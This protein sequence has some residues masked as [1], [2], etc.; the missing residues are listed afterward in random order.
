MR[1]TLLG[2]G[3]GT[4]ESVTAEACAAMNEADLVTGAPRL[5]EA[6]PEIPGQ[7]RV[8]SVRAGEILELL[9]GAERV[10]V[11][12]SGDTGFYSGARLLIPELRA[13]GVEYRV[14]P[15]ISS[16][17]ILA[18]RLGRPWQDWN[19]Y[20][21]HGVDCDPVAAVM[22]DKPAFFLTGGE[23]GPAELCHMLTDVSL[24]DLPVTVGENLTRPDERIL[25]G[26][27]AEF[28]ERHFAPLSVMLVEAAPVPYPRRTP[29]IPDG[30]FIRGK[31]PMT[32]Q[33][34]R[35]AALGKLA[36]RPTDTVWDVG[37]GTGSV[38]VEL[39]MAAR[40]GRVYAVE[41]KPEACALIQQNREKFGVWNLR[42]ITGRAPEVLQ[43]LPPPDAVFL[44]GSGGEMS[45]IA[46]V[47]LQKNP[48]ARIC[49]SAIALE[50]LTAAVSALEAHGLAAEVTQIAVSRT[51]SA[52][53]LHLLMANNPVFL[54]TAERGAEA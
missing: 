5:L 39:A 2:L 23:L 15:G 8:P 26:T 52:G 28:A 29:G 14:Q 32:K 51:K 19:L 44:G 12:Y 48:A 3:G 31:V 46:G 40:R 21:A 35:A 7:R 17:Q 4:M 45:A 50:S 47:V 22:E 16:V 54:I 42:L 34:V 1:V 20:S 27:T 6:L 30:D 53:R 37:A 43:E 38:S 18:A 24:G 25:H 49:I 10:C 13:R 41:C 33:E 9:S 36:V 11:V